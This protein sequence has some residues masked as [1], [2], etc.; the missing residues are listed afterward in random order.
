D[1]AILI[2][3]M[4]RKRRFGAQLDA[5]E[6][7]ELEPLLG[8][9]PA[10]RQEGMQALN[11]QILGDEID[12]TAVIAYLTRRAYRDEWLYEPA[13]SL[14]PTRTWSKLDD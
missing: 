5:I 12:D 3:I 6:C 9:R 10:S 4:D 8:F 1:A 2:K 11:E 13:V 14:Y 7:D